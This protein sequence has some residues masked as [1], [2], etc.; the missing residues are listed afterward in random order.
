MNK[1]TE[2][3]VFIGRFLRE[4]WWFLLTYLVILCLMGSTF[5]L[6]DVE[7]EV[8]TDVILFTFPV[9]IVVLGYRGLRLWRK[10]RLLVNIRQQDWFHVAAENFQKAGLLE[11]DYQALLNKLGSQMDELRDKHQ[12]QE[13]EWRDYYAL[14]SHQIKTPLATL[15]LLSESTEA[16]VKKE[17]KEEIFKT[18]Q[19]LD[20]MLQYLRLQSIHHDFRFEEISLQALVKQTIKKYAT[21]FIRKDLEVALNHINGMI[22]TDEKWLQFI[23]EQVIFNAIKYTKTGGITVYSP[24]QQPDVLCIKDTGQGI[25][26]EDLPRVFERGYTGFNGRENEASSGLGLYMCKEIANQLGIRL[27]ITSVINEGTEVTIDATQHVRVID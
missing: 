13:K 18:Q 8:Y 7:V 22:I 1:I 16:A 19:Y 5:F 24:K 11:Q 4:D 20:M 3:L 23:L 14:W 26:P 6:Y 17:M 2:I 27:S 25:L 9:F 10:H 21:F 15:N 12:T